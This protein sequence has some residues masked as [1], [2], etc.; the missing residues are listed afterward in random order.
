MHDG[1]D[2]GCAGQPRTPARASRLAGGFFQGLVAAWP[3]AQVATTELTPGHALLERLGRGRRRR[4]CAIC[5]DTLRPY[6]RV[7][8]CPC[9]PEAPLCETAVHF[10]VLRQLHCW[11]DWVSDPEHLS[12]PAT[13][14]KLSSDP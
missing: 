1:P 14:R 6:D 13:S 4:F 7:V 12:C 11:H 3:D 10:D 9:Q 5:G 2:L 8:I